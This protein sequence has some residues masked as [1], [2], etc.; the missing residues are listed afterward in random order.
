MTKIWYFI[1]KQV[2]KIKVLY[3]KWVEWIFKGFYK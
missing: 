2:R 3:D 1:K